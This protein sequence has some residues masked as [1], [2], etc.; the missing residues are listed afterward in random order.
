V[1]IKAVVD[2]GDPIFWMMHDERDG[3]PAF[4]FDLM[5]PERPEV[6]PCG[7][8]FLRHRVRE[9]YDREDGAVI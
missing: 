3:S 7:R 2:A 1:Q 9:I 6:G 5:E 4:V 8:C